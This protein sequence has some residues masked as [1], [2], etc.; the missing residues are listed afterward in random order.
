MKI[1]KIQ[2][3]KFNKHTLDKQFYNVS[4]LVTSHPFLNL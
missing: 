2:K 3:P 4:L 1:L